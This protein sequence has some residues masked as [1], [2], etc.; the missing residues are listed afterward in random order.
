M[1]GCGHRGL[2]ALSL[3]PAAVERHEH[4]SVCARTALEASLGQCVRSGLEF[5]EEEVH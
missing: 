2:D 4:G 3:L 1:G 5:T